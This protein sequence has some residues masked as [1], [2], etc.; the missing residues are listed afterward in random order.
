MSKALNILVISEA[1]PSEYGQAMGFVHSRNQYYINHNHKVVVLSFTA[2]SKYTIDNIPV[3]SEKSFLQEYQ[4]KDFDVIV[5]HA[6]NLKNHFR[7]LLKHFSKINNLVFIVHG[8]EVLIKSKYYPLPFPKVASKNW[9][10]WRFINFVY[11]HVK[12]VILQVLLKFLFLKKSHLVFVSNWMKSEFFKNVCISPEKIASKTHVISNAVH[13]IFEH[14]NYDH[15]EMR[16]KDFITLRRFDGA[17]YAIDLVVKAATDNPDY[18]FHVYGDGMYFDHYPYPDNLKV[19]K[20]FFRQDEIPDLLN[21]YKGAIMPT[22]L[23]AQGVMVCEMA[24]F[25]LPVVT[26]DIPVCREVLSGFKNVLFL[27]N[28]NF[29]F[30]AKSFLA[31]VKKDKPGQNKTFFSENT[32]A[33]ELTIFESVE[34]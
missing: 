5:S 17:K 7:F 26:S 28:E 3:V 30:D 32:I 1:Y 12:V 4:L 6:P 8:H 31:N 14:V 25:G 9:A 29:K 19:F 27:S 2:N 23:D 15:S 20:K 11:D 34:R 10:A 33:K 21:Q 13:P 22:R 16:E 24:T 18:N